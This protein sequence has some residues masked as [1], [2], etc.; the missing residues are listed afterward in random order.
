M[1]INLSLIIK[2]FYGLETLK[3]IYEI[4]LCLSLGMEM[5]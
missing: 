5:G 4:S 1:K 3:F 2:D